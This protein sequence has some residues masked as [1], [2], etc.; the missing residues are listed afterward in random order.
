MVQESDF[1]VRVYLPVCAFVLAGVLL[2][3][4]AP[5]PEK[6][7]FRFVQATLGCSLLL[8]VVLSNR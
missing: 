2:S 7:R 8:A 1:A 5:V 3:L 6:Y 4:F